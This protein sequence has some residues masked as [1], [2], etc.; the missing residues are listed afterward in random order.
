MS[1]RRYIEFYS[2]FRNRTQYPSQASF[3]VPFAFS[4]QVISGEN[5]ADPICNGS[6]YYTWS[7]ID[8]LSV[9]IASETSS[10]RGSIILA[11]AS[12]L[13]PIHNYY[14]GYL[15]YNTITLESRVIVG[16]DSTSA[17]FILQQ[18]YNSLAWAN[19]NSYTILNPSTNNIIYIPSEDIYGNKVKHYANAYTD[20][21]II[22]ETL[23]ISGGPVIA[24]KII[25][26]DFTTQYATLDKPFQGGWTK[27]DSYTL[28]NNIPMEKYILDT[29][30]MNN[31]VTSTFL[32]SNGNP[33]PG[34]IINLP[35]NQGNQLKN[36]YVGK[37]VYHSFNNDISPNLYPNPIVNKEINGGGTYGLYFI[38]AS[39]LNQTS[40]Q[41]Q[42]L[43]DYDN[44]QNYNGENIPNYDNITSKGSSINIISFSRDNFSPLNYNGSVVSQSETVCYEVSLVSLIMPNVNL[45]SGARAIFYP[46]FYIEL[47][48]VTSPSGASNDIIY[49]NN[50]FSNKALFIAPVTDTVQPVNSNFIKIYSNMSQTIK[51]KPNDSFKFSIYLPDGKP[52][53]TVESDYLSPYSPNETIQI[54]AVFGIRRI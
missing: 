42:L 12:G 31:I 18:P 14:C 36:Y 51:F 17:R 33:V 22:D 32:N 27:Y 13:S 20:Y 9:P 3:S 46:F 19:N 48:N 23:S 52:F 6:I 4:R 44:N 8:P 38:K 34:Y 40:G 29:P 21:Y 47:S 25:S 53:E 45:K 30:N 16:Y 49:S 1:N 26:Y 2:K 24:S 35:L 39:E 43:V 11:T 7:G 54:D 50:P 37:Y 5:A 28:R 15:L 10:T 41:I